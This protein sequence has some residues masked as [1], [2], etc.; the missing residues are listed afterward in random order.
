MERQKKFW[1]MLLTAIIFLSVAVL[2]V[3]AVYRVD[4]V[5]LEASVVSDEAKIEADALQKKLEEAY[6]T[7]SIFF[8]GDAQAK[9]VLKE[10]PYFRLT[11]FE[12]SYPNRVIVKI[13]EDAEIYAVEKGNGEY[14]ILGEDGG[15]LAVRDSYIN[16]L[17]GSENVLLK[18]VSVQGEY[19]SIPVGD[20][21]FPSMLT[22][23]KELSSLLGGIRS[24]VVS[25]EVYLKTPEVIYRV[26]MREGINLYVGAPAEHTAEKAKAAIDKYLS[27]SN[28]EKLSGRIVVSEMGGRIFADYA[29]KDEFASL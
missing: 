14:Y 24:N 8:V 4:R 9:K 11:G 27:L 20:S 5:T 16:P 18:G 1:V 10:F 2:G 26:K 17:T 22:L 25:V 12:K 7:A 21:Y 29:K 13:I 28:E 6:D 3:S 19:G 15:V 23:C